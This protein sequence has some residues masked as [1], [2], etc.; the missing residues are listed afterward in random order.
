MHR[1][2]KEFRADKYVDSRSDDK[3]PEPE[4]LTVGKIGKHTFLFVA[5]ERTHDIF[6]YDVSVPTAPVLV[7]VRLASAP[8][9][10]APCPR[11]P[12][13][14]SSPRWLRPLPTLWHSLGAT[15]APSAAHKVIADAGDYSP[16][17]LDFIPASDSPSGKAMLAI[18]YEWAPDGESPKFALYESGVAPCATGS[19]DDDDDPCFARG[20]TTACRVAP[21]ASAAEVGPECARGESVLMSELVAGDHVLASPTAVTRVIVN[22]HVPSKSVSSFVTLHHAGG[23]LTLTPDHVVLLNGE[24]APAREAKAGSILSNGAA[25][26]RVTTTT[27]GII[28]PLTTAGTILANGVIASVYPEW[29]AAHMLSTK[30]YPLPLSASNLVSY[31]FPQSAQAFYNAAL[32]PLFNANR[33]HLEAVPAALVT[34]AIA[35][36]DLLITAAF[37]AP[38]ALAALVLS[39]KVKA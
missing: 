35:I 18:G 22:Q 20:S 8:H 34:P 15:A 37:L 12:R 9:V 4:G 29:I 39:R 28:N 2:Y 24:W 32:E 30:V 25:V 19:D 7:Q 26:E 13:I 10:P 21:G 31:L 23:A 1:Y 27:D 36:L 6:I 38:P 14:C 11:Q 33:K 16:E 17:G 5:M 3:G